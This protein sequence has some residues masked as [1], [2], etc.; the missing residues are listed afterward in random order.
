MSNARADDG[1]AAL[2][3][4]LRERIRRDGPMPVDRYMDACLAEPQHGYWHRADTIGAAGAFITAPE[5]SQMF[6][7]PPLPCHPPQGGRGSRWR[8]PGTKRLIKY[9]TAPPW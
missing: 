6:C 9:P 1:E 5:I 3:E 2:L 4:V 8:L 7:H